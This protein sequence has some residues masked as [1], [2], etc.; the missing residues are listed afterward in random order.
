MKT[1]FTDTEL[2]CRCGCGVKPTGRTIELLYA[3]R[4]LYDK[5]IRISSGARC[6]SY[7][8]EVNGSPESYHVKGMAFDCKIPKEDELQFI[9]MATLCKFKGIGFKDNV[10]IH[11][12][13][14][15][16]DT[17]WGY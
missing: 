16:N 10:F 3:L 11:I 17:I 13:C 12:D 1:Y 8:N 15:T 14:R 6:Q 4:I 9:R 5:P 2:N 7:N